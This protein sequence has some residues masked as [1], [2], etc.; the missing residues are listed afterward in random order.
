LIAEDA[1]IAIVEMVQL[2]YSINGKPFNNMRCW[3]VKFKNDVIV[4]VRAYLY[5]SLVQALVNENPVKAK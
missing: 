4:H 1:P 5:S 2:S 3:I